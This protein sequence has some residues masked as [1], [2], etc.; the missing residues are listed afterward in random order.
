MQQW[1]CSSLLDLNL[2][3]EDIFGS[4]SEEDYNQRVVRS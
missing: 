1:S 2:E 3:K 4:E